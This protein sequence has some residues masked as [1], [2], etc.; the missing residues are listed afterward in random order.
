MADR[1]PEKSPAQITQ[2]TL[3]YTTLKEEMM[4]QQAESVLMQERERHR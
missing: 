1:C 3:S 2:W 4:L